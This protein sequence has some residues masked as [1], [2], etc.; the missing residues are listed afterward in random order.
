MKAVRILEA[1]VVTAHGAAPPDGPTA[2]RGRGLTAGGLSAL[3]TT[4]G[5]SSDAALL[6]VKDLD[7]GYRAD[8]GLG[9]PRRVV[10]SGASFELRPGRLLALLGANGSGKTTL[11]K[12]CV[13]LLPSLGGQVLIDSR[14]VG[15]MG[16]RHLARLVAW[17]PQQTEP[18]WSYTARE[19]VAQARY[20]LLG[21]FKPFGAEDDQAVDAALEV[22]DARPLADRTFGTLS[23]GEARRILIARALAQDTPLVALD[24]PA[25]HLDPGRQMELLE[26]LRALARTGK[27]VLVSLHD[28]NAARRYADEVALIDRAGGCRWGAPEEALA[29]ERLEEAYDTEFLHGHVEG[30]GRFVLPLSKRKKG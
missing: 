4:A 27:A 17:V 23:G 21:P 8:R 24:E 3:S 30:Y 11:L 22:M 29:P 28:V 18:A 7:A 16:P 19:L 20:A 6:S 1:S 12:T 13:G 14:P 9:V 5:N 26:T 25:A 2:G 10:V 15:R